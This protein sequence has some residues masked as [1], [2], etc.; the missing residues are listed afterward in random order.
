MY[1]DRLPLIYGT[2][3]KKEDTKDLVIKA[4]KAGFRG[5]DTACQPKHY[6]EAGVG[7]ALVFLEK[8]GI[9]RE[10]LFLQTKF[11][12]LEGQDP[13]NV[14]YDKKAELN[15]QVLQSFEVSKTNLQTNYVDSLILHSPPTDFNDLEIVWRAMEEIAIRGEAKE[16]GISNIYDI[17]ILE[18]LYEMAEIKPTVVQNRFHKENSFD[19]E[20]RSFCTT[21]NI[22]YQGFWTLT[23]NVDILQSIELFELATKYDKNVIQVFFAYLNQIGIVPLTGTS[24]IEHMKSDLDSFH[25]ILEESELS[26]L[27]SLL[28]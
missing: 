11:T 10:D 18:C 27:N 19:K 15:V 22:I 20:I 7:E 26:R 25:I 2:A 3:W 12:L 16:L 13:L 17:D 14:P 1:A 21:N 4:V 9:K 28:E 6:N 5:I 23:A 8:E 24:D